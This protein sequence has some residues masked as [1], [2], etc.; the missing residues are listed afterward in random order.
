LYILSC[1][2]LYSLDSET[3]LVLWNIAVDDQGADCTN[4]A[5]LNILIAPESYV[6]VACRDKQNPLKEW[7][8]YKIDPDTEVPSRPWYYTTWGIVGTAAVVYF[9]MRRRGDYEVIR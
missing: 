7:H 5:P 2:Q 1:G 3:G 8:F 9:I 4:W 6:V